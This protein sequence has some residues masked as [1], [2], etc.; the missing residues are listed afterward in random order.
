[1]VDLHRVAPRQRVAGAGHG[2]Q[3]TAGPFGHSG[4]DRVGYHPVVGAVQHEHR[5]ADGAA[6]LASLLGR[7]AGLRGEVVD[8]DVGGG[9]QAPA[10]R[11]LEP[12]GGVRVG[13]HRRVE[14]RDEAGVVGTDGIESEPVVLDRRRCQR[15]HAGHAVRVRGGEGEAAAGSE[16]QPDDHHPVRAG[17][18]EHGDQVGDVLLD[19]VGGGSDRAVAAPVAPP[20][21]DHHPE[22]PREERHLRLPLP[23][24]HDRVRGGQQDRRRRGVRA[25][26][27]L[28]QAAGRRPASGRTRTDRG[29]AAGHAPGRAT[30]V[31]VAVAPADSA[32]RRAEE[33]HD[34]L[35]VADRREAALTQH[36]HGRTS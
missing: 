25:S 27:A 28:S 24:V 20:V 2:H 17:R 18:V 36:D 3:R 9:L 1:M 35:V 34:G 32:V 8:H 11:V 22:V 29:T 21:D 14:E 15:D 33:A 4:A 6:Q 13:E 30:E 7:T 10:D 26:R 19:G 23:G 31:L 16:G 12:L 5:A